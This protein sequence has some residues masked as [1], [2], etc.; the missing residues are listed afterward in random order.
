M[1]NREEIRK[2]EVLL[3]RFK[4]KKKGR[5]VNDERIKVIFLE[6]KDMYVCVF[7]MS[8]SNLE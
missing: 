8:I 2:L 5:G 6:V 7:E 3:R 4:I 1:E